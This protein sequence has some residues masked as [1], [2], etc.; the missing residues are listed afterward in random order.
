MAGQMDGIALA[1]VPLVHDLLE[2]GELVEL[3]DGRCRLTG[4]SAY[5][6]IQMPLAAERPELARFVDW[7]R[8]EAA[9]TRA[10]IGES[11]QPSAPG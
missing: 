11:A 6:L 8:T 3:F 2:R 1:R 9:V 10:A 5:Y 4:Q 7:V